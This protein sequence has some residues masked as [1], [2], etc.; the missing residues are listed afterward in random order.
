MTQKTCR[1]VKQKHLQSHETLETRH[2]AGPMS[3][4][5][6]VRHE[7]Q[8]NV[9]MREQINEIADERP[10]WMLLQHRVRAVNYLL[11]AVW[12]ICTYTQRSMQRWSRITVHL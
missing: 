6:C 2:N 10:V 7:V 11:V 4:Q 3:Q 5:C 8:S 9:S 1:D 12:T